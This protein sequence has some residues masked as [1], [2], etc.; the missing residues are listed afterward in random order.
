MKGSID[1]HNK[2]SKFQ[3][4]PRSA[5]LEQVIEE[6]IRQ[7]KR[8]ADQAHWSFIVASVITTTSTL[9]ALGGA[10]LLLTDKVSEGTVTGAVGVVSGVYSYQLFKDAADRQKEADES[11]DQMLRELEDEDE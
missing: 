1:K 7:C 2:S 3:R 8:T 10:G 6:R 5:L 9:F 4:D 11:L